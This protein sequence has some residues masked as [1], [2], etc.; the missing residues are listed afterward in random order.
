MWSFAHLLLHTNQPRSHS[1]PLSSD[2]PHAIRD[3]IGRV[4]STRQKDHLLHRCCCGS[5]SKKGPVCFRLHRSFRQSASVS[6]SRGFHAHSTP[7]A[8][9][10][11]PQ[12][13]LPPSA[14]AELCRK[15]PL[16]LL[17]AEAKRAE[18]LARNQ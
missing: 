13:D 3:L 8:I 2:E 14:S 1:I 18:R 6:Y 15:L 17:A 11:E 16:R 5:R 4:Q 12:S 7:Q 9:Q 10:A